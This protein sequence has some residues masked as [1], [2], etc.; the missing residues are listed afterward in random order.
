M[1]RFCFVS[2]HIDCYE[3][4][5]KRRQPEDIHGSAE[6][7]SQQQR[8]QLLEAAITKAAG[9]GNYKEAAELQESLSALGEA[10]CVC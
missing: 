8:R 1:H 7:D 4:Y 5:Q 6:D 10:S 3:Y 2:Q 9:L